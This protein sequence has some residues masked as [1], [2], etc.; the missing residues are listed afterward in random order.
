MQTKTARICSLAAIA[1]GVTVA[2]ACAD[3]VEQIDTTL[4]A[5]VESIAV[6]VDTAAGRVIGRD[7]EPA[8]L[9]AVIGMYNDAE[10]ETGQLGQRKATDSAVRAFARQIVTDHRALK[11]E[12]TATVQGMNLAPADPDDAND[13]RESHTEAMRKLNEAARGREFDEAFIQHEI[14]MHE[15]AVADVEDALDD[16]EHAA[17]RPFLEK[18][19]GG[20]RGHLARAREL[21]EGLGA[22]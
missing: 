3:K 9:V 2:T 13:L 5:A 16:D 10:I 21:K 15:R 6:A 17:L 20:L 11:T 7:Y 8:E 12:A 14:E 1:A 19:L 18:A 4:S 22:R